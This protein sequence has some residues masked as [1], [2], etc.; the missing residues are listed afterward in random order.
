MAASWSSLAEAGRDRLGLAAVDVEAVED[1]LRAVVVAADE[2]LA[3]GVAAVALARR[4]ELDV[5]GA[6]AALAAA[7]AREPSHDLL[8]GDLEQHREAERPAGRLEGDVERLDLRDRARVAVEDEAARR[9]ALGQ[10]VGHHVVDQLVGHELAGAHEV[11]G[12]TPQRRPFPDRSAQDVAGRE[13]RD[14]LGVREQA[15]LRPLAHAG[16]AEQHEHERVLGLEAAGHGEVS[17]SEGP[18]GKAGTL[19][20]FE[21]DVARNY[22]PE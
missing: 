3:V 14:P 19:P 22:P 5:V 12:L 10:A 16:R 2:R 4:V 13:Q 6:A 8:V 17:L 1:R 15:A 21:A 9:V 18:G 7:P 20:A 11:L